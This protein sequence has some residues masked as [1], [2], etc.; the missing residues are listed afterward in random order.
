MVLF[1]PSRHFRSLYMLVLLITCMYVCMYVCMYIY[2][3]VCMYV[4]SVEG[5][6]W[7]LHKHSELWLVRHRESTPE[8]NTYRVTATTLQ[9]LQC[10]LILQTSSQKP[11]MCS[12]YW[13]RKCGGKLILNP[14]EHNH[15]F[16]IIPLYLT[17]YLQN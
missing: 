14:T 1:F 12:D 16:I 11:P 17:V 9:M 10:R 6:S 13:R 4:C 3:Y 2:T 5:S 8:G 7:N 15:N